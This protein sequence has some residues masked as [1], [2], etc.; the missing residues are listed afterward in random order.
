MLEILL[1]IITGILT[2]ITTFTGA[3]AIKN[4]QCNS[5][6]CDVIL[7]TEPYN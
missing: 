7:E 5:E 4:S 1:A 3:L 6:C 2:I